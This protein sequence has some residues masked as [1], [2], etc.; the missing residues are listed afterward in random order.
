MKK[1]EFI[2]RMAKV[3]CDKF[4][5]YEI[6]NYVGFQFRNAY[7]E[8][9]SKLGKYSRWINNFVDEHGKLPE[10]DYYES[11]FMLRQLVVKMFEH[12]IIDHTDMLED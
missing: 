11:R 3:D 12:F 2:E 10:S 6:W 5:C 8:E 1:K 9:F 4:T 7:Q